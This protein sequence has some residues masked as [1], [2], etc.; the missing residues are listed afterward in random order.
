MKILVA[1][2]TLAFLFYV[3]WFIVKSKGALPDEGKFA[4]KNDDGIPDAFQ[5]GGRPKGSKNKPKKK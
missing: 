5:K 4:D 1:L 2:V 3:G